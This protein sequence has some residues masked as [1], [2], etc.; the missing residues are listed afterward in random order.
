MIHI[1]KNPIDIVLWILVILTICFIY[2]WAIAGHNYPDYLFAF[3][4]FATCIAALS[5]LAMSRRT[6]IMSAVNSFTIVFL[7]VIPLLGRLSGIIYWGESS[8]IFNYYAAASLITFLCIT[9]LNITYHIALKSNQH[10]DSNPETDGDFKVNT[11]AII[12]ISYT[13]L[14]IIAAYN[15]F[16][17]ISMMVRDGIFKEATDLGSGIAQL[18]FR[19]AIY[20]IPAI[21]FCIYAAFG[22]RKMS[23]ILLLS[24]PLL[25]GNA[26]TGS[27]RFMAAAIYLA[28][29]VSLFPSMARSNIRIPALIIIGIMIIFPTLDQ[30]RYWEGGMPSIYIINAEILRHGHF[31]TFQSIAGALIM[32]ITY[33]KQILGVLLFW[34]PRTL[35]PSKPIGS[36]AEYAQ[37]SNLIFDNISMNFFAEGIINFGAIGAVL[38]AMIGAI[39]ASKFDS[40]TPHIGAAPIRRKIMSAFMLGLS[41]YMMRG[42]LLSSFAFTCGVIS[43]IWL[44][45]NITTRQIH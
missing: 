40:T 38:F 43:S 20:P 8:T 30:F 25:I 23:I 9:L 18:I 28:V 29:L 36:G 45:T 33:G 34:V 12:I 41:I 3:L 37:H 11:L 4:N 39:A 35:W 16:S 5:G 1:K 22:N 6:G 2:I 13:S 44:V 27:P 7:C 15:N 26:P 21:C 14:I 19:T 31:D 32:P 42:D 17:L 10:I 24:I